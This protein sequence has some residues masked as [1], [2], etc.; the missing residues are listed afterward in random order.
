M[1][2]LENI[3]FKISEK[4]YSYKIYHKVR[5]M[6]NSSE[7]FKSNFDYYQRVAKSCLKIINSLEP[8]R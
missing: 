2:L 1:L 4:F 7:A 5:E 3:N 6:Q 8:E